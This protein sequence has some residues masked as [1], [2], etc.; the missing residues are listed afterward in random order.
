MFD[1][2]PHGV[3]PIIRARLALGDA[4]HVATHTQEVLYVLPLGPPGPLAVIS[5]S[6]AP[7]HPPKAQSMASIHSCN[8]WISV[9][10]HSR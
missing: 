1:S 8:S 3:L 7:G 10:V 6:I 5:S 9:T 4:G 2:I